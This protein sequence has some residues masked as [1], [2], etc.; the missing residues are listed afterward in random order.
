MSILVGPDRAS[1]LVP[2]FLPAARFDASASQY[3]EVLGDGQ[4]VRRPAGQHRP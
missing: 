2:L 4:V 1:E 3:Y